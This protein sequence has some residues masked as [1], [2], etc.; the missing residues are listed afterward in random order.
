MPR[1]KINKKRFQA[2][3]SFLSAHPEVKKFSEYN[4]CLDEEAYGITR[5]DGETL[6]QDSYLGAIPIKLG[7][8]IAV[9]TDGTT[10][11]VTPVYNET[12][13]ITNFVI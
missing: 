10:F 7:D 8:F 6:L 1:I 2:V 9:G 4:Q 12:N 3:K 11:K 13:E 5:V